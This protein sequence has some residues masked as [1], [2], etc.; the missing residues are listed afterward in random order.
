[1]IDQIWTGSINWELAILSAEFNTYIGNIVEHLFEF[2][3][4]LRV[5]ICFECL[6]IRG[7]ESIVT[8]LLGLKKDHT[9][10]GDG[11]GR[12]L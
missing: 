12:G 4:E 2:I 10:S 11:S 9:T 5:K 8:Q 1:M 7:D 3:T 6:G